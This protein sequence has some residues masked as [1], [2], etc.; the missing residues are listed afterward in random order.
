MAS[1]LK[2]NTIQHTGGTTGLTIDSSGRV[3]RSN[4]PAFFATGSSSYVAYSA[5]DTLQFN[6][7]SF[8]D[9][10]NYNTSTYRFVA[11]VTGLY[12]FGAQA[13]IENDNPAGLILKQLNASNGVIGTFRGFQTGRGPQINTIVKMTATDQMY[14]EVEQDG[15]SFYLGAGYGRFYGYLIG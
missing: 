14:V 2:V 12:N 1:T 10:G 5:G 15:N 8:D 7:E 3:F 4:I 9:G 11:P 13:L 6:S